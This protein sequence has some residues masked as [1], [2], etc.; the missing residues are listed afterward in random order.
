M[1]RRVDDD[2]SIPLRYAAAHSHFTP[3]TFKPHAGCRFM[4]PEDITGGPA[5]NELISATLSNEPVTFRKSNGAV[6]I[7]IEELQEIDASGGVIF[8]GKSLP[9]DLRGARVSGHYDSLSETL[10]IS[11][12]GAVIRPTA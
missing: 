1:A 4:A 7:R 12:D 6:Q 2:L 8:F 10:E 9:E 5:K 11:V 3:G